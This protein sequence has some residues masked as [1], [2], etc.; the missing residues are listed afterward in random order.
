MIDNLLHLGDSH[1]MNGHKE[2]EGVYTTIDGETYFKITNY[3]QM[4]TFFMTVVSASDHWLFIASNGGIS[5]GRRNANSPLFPYYTDDKIVDLAHITGSKT[6]IKVVID[7]TSFLWEPFVENRPNTYACVRN[8]YKNRT[9]NKVMFEEVNEDLDVVFRYTWTFSEKYGFVKQSMLVNTS[10]EPRLIEVV[11]GIQNLLPYGVTMEMQTNRSTLVNAYKKNELDEQTGLGVYSLSS[12]IV[13]KAEP[14]EALSATTTWSAG[15]GADNL[16]ISSTQLAHFR[17]GKPLE[18]ELDVRAQNGAYFVNNQRFYK[19]GSTQK[20]CIVSEVN[21]SHNDVIN[22]RKWLQMEHDHYD[23][24]L[25]D[26]NSG[27]SELQLLV[28]MSDGMQL[29][30][31]SLSVGRHYSN[32]LFNIMR[33]GVF[34]EG[35]SIRKKELMDFVSHWN[36]NVAEEHHSFWNSIPERMDNQELATKAKEY[37]N[38]DV[39]RLCLEF[40]PLYFSRRHGDPSRPWN[41]FSINT[42]NEDGGKLHNYEGNWRDIFQNWEALAFSYP[43]YIEAF[44]TKFVNASTMD[45][46]NPY[47]IS[48]DGVDWEV[49]DEDDPWSYIGYWGDHQLIYLLKLLEAYHVHHPDQVVDLLNREVYV[50]ANV[51]YRIKSYGETISNPQDTIDFDQELEARIQKRVGKIGSDGKLVVYGDGQIARAN[52]LEKLVISLFTKLYN[53]VPDAGIWLNTQ[54]PEWND[55]NNALVGNGV[56]MVTLYY[57]RRYLNFM[58][59]L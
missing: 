16:L 40:L 2:V 30:G 31:D 25:E 7:G 29:T 47:R 19:S 38:P 32:V 6:L 53:Y 34:D 4:D 5:A 45:G 48:T 17:K 35:Y 18:T 39:L 37:N 36:R 46:Y 58:V 52:L 24:V 51:P 59:N 10:S 56:S 8:I 42:K 15:L 12:M 1:I 43:A 22:L 11:D 27:T 13:D 3:D 21:Q 9:G 28:G 41:Y 20:W 26:V 44:I 23:L 14:S 54:R 49:V 57:L 50:F 33:G 55:A